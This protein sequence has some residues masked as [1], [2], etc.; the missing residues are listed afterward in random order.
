MCLFE[1]ANPNYSHCI[2]NQQ[3]S[4]TSATTCIKTIKY[5]QSEDWQLTGFN[6]HDYIPNIVSYY[7]SINTKFSVFLYRQT[8]IQAYFNHVNVTQRNNTKMYSRKVQQSILYTSPN[9]KAVRFEKQIHNTRNYFFRYSFLIRQLTL[10]D[11]CS[12]LKTKFQTLN[13]DKLIDALKK[14]FTAIPRSLKE[15]SASALKVWVRQ[16]ECVLAQR[17]RRGQQMVCL[18]TKLWEEHALREFLRKMRQHML[19]RGK[20]FMLG[21][22][23]ITSYNWDK[24]RMP[25]SEIRKHMDEIR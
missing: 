13:K 22:V 2:S 19:K 15:H 23:G 1:T 24:N 17:L 9:L 6:F 7:P 4:T 3:H 10:D 18:Y 16:C 21:A 20:E 25:D 5:W 11:A 14:S 8:C 12:T